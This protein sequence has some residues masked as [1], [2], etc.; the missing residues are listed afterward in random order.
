MYI[1]EILEAQKY[2][3]IIL[4]HII[5][6]L[7]KTKVYEN[8]MFDVIQNIIRIKIYNNTKA[9]K[10]VNGVKQFHGLIFWEVVPLLVRL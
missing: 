3:E 9:G 10:G 5:V 8:I 4:R 7:L 2:K 1:Q 6:N